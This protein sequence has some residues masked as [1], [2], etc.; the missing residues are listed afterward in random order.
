VKAIPAGGP[1]GRAVSGDDILAATIQ[2]VYAKQLWPLLARSLSMAAHGDGTGIRAIAD[3]FYG[4]NPD[5]TYDPFTDRYFTLSA[6][7]Q[8]YPSTVDTFLDAG[9]HSWGLFDHAWWNSGYAELPWGLY[10]VTA[11]DAFGGPFRVNADSP[12]VLVVGTTYDPATPYRGAK[13][14]VTQLGQARLLTMRGDGHTA[15]GGNSPCIDGAVDA[16]LISH[17]VPAA[18]TVCRQAVPFAQPTGPAAAQTLDSGRSLLGPHVKPF[19][20][21]AR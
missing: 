18:G 4:R 19:V 6:D 20:R 12:T 5:G 11:R 15:Y 7:E 8:R 17:T 9:A 14:L 16:Y 21:L 1:G 3:F 2:A 13:R 10:P